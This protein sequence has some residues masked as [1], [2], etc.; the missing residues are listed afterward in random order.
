M[1]TEMPN[2]KNADADYYVETIQRKVPG[3]HLIYELTEHILDAFLHSLNPARLLILGAGGGQELVTLG[4][5]TDW[6][7]TG[8]DTSAPMLQK[9]QERAEQAGLIK[10]VRLL[11]GTIEDTD[12]GGKYDG[13]TCML[14]LHFLRSGQEQLDLLRALADR[15]QTGA[16]LMISSVVMDN[17]QAQPALPLMKAWQKHMK[18]GGISEEE[19]ERFAA[20]LGKE[21]NPIPSS[22][23]IRLLTAAG[24]GQ[25]ECYFRALHVEAYYAVK[26]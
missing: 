6:E 10:R 18:T 13:A 21:S 11:Q 2:W 8:V 9:A 26:V 3:Y 15:L 20:S 24:F 22:E 23:L 5:H 19:W 12:L 16:P 7:F 1:K 25:I 14:M 17:D 4:S